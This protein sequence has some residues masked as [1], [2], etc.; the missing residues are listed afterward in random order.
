[1][2]V[3]RWQQR[4]R[5]IPAVILIT[6][7]FTLLFTGCVSE[8]PGGSENSTNNTIQQGGLTPPEDNTSSTLPTGNTTPVVEKGDMVYIDYIGKVQ[9]TGQVFATS[10]EDVA[11]DPSIPKVEDFEIMEDYAPINFVVGENVGRLPDIE[12]GVV[13]MKVGEEKEIIAP[14]ERAYGLRDERLVTTEPRFLYVPKIENVSIEAII[15]GFRDVPEINSTL[16]LPYWNA[17]VLD[18]SNRTVTLKHLVDSNQTIDTVLGKAKIY[19]NESYIILEHF[20]EINRTIRVAYGKTAKIIKVNE[21]S[22]VLDR[23]DPL[24]GETLVFQIKVVNLIKLDEMKKMKIYWIEDY[25]KGL[26]KASDESKPI[27]LYIY[28]SNCEDCELMD[29]I[30]FSNPYIKAMRDDFI[31]IKINNE[32]NPDISSRFPSQIYPVIILLKSDG[33]EISKTSGFLNADDMLAG[34][35]SVDDYQ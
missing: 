6:S 24:A 14:P 10:Y 1:M 7:L 26:K 2:M 19:T 16:T 3:G 32:T 9:S 5:V 33:T 27:I 13:G 8:G 15:R 20:P 21:T 17:T 22:F 30:T 28:S 4:M 23:N 11:K 34:L 29:M 18:V 31:W 25:D 35:R 12:D